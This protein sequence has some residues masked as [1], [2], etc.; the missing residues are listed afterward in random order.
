MFQVKYLLGN[1]LH[2]TFHSID[3]QPLRKATCLRPGRMLHVT[4]PPT[5]EGEDKVCWIMCFCVGCV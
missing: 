5:P 3:G 2:R 4:H 1:P